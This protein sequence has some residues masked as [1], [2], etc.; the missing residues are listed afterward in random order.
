MGDDIVAQDVYAEFKEQVIALIAGCGVER[1]RIVLM[2]PPRREFGDL[3]TNVAFELAAEAGGNPRRVAQELLDRLDCRGCDLVERAAVAGAGYLN[4]YID[5]RQY[6]PRVLGAIA[7]G[8]SHYADLRP[9]MP[10]Q[11]IVEHTSVNPNKPW[12]VGHARNAILGDTLGRLFRK[13]GYAVEIQNYIDDTGIQVAETIYALDRFAPTEGGKFDH[14]VGEAYVHLHQLLDAEEGTPSEELATIRAGVEAVLRE[15]EEGVHRPFVER[16]L[17]AQLETAGR[18]G[19]AYDFL[20]WESDIIRA[21]LLQEAMARIQASP[22]VHVAR[23]GPQQG[24]LIIE[25]GEFLGH[26]D[27]D[28]EHLVDKILIRSNGLPT[29]TAKDIAFQMWKFGLLENEMRYAR[30]PRQANG[31]VLWTTHPQGGPQKRPPAAAVYN[32]I[33]SEQ[34]YPQAV[35]RAALKILGYEQE[36]ARSHHLSYEHVA[37]PEGRMSGRRGIGVSADEVVE[38]TIAEAYRVV[39]EKQGSA[40][41]EE[42]MAAIAEAVGVGAVR[43]AMLRTSPASPVTFKLSDVVNFA[44]YT[45]LYIQ[46]AYVRALR[47]LAKAREAGETWSGEGVTAGSQALGGEDE[48]TLVLQLSLLPSAIGDALRRRDPSLVCQYAYDLAQAFGQFYE[49][50][51]VLGAPVELKVARLQLVERTA[52]VLRIVMDLLGVPVVERL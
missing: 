10:G 44:G 25:M 43:L 48:R 6:I 49:I 9:D 21:R 23:E 12:H 40:L 32:V 30:G 2:T 5:Y 18:L 22:H 47:I 35:V 45:A 52:T 20:I 17:S 42:E 51:P 24:C 15:L 33:G 36:Y 37:L 46:Y 8:G 39:R 14:R 19:I 7:E 29:Y 1:E 38:A 50:S 31:Q 34:E 16:C 26:G 11:I 13:A 41:P 3:S 28:G 4:F 27:A